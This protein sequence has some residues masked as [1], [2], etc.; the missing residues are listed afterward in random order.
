MGM[1]ARESVAYRVASGFSQGHHQKERTV[2]CFAACGPS[3][4]LG[5]GRQIMLLTVFHICV[6]PLNKNIVSLNLRLLTLT[7]FSVPSSCVLI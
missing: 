4:L 3:L 2:G 6:V 7:H 1:R 5:F